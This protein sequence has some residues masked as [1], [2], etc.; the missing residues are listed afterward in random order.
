M[1]DGEA[2]TCAS[3]GTPYVRSE[4]SVMSPSCGYRY[5]RSSA[6]QQ[7]AAYTVTATTTW[8]VTWSGGGETGALTVTRSSTAQVRIGEL[9]VL[10]S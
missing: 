8:A 3:P 6:Q 9:Q 7:G 4:G 2:V 10:V 5:E 1:G